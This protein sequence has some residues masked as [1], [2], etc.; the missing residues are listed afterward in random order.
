MLDAL[1]E[2][3]DLSLAPVTLSSAAK[4][5]SRQVEVFSAR[6]ACESEHYSEACEVVTSGEFKG[7]TLLSNDTK[8]PE[9]PKG[10]F[11]QALSDAM[12][13]RLMPATEKAL[14]RADDALNPD[15]Y[16]QDIYLQ[17]MGRLRSACCA[18]N[19]ALGFVT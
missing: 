13:A 19:L 17:S 14:S 7:V 9:I 12:S 11:Y 4:L 1:E 2:L 6:T 16:P 18:T 3:S 15:T 8:Q 5:I 10:Q